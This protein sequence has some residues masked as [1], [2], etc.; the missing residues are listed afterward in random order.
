M[1]II[2]AL[3]LIGLLVLALCLKKTPKDEVSSQDITLTGFE[4]TDVTNPY[5]PVLVKLHSIDDSMWVIS[6]QPSSTKPNK[7]E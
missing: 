6:P 3:L 2:I 7:G 5:S 4:I 1:K